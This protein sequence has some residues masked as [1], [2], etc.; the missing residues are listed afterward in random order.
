MGR[1]CSAAI[2]SKLPLFK[3]E[4]GWVG[5]IISCAHETTGI[6]GMNRALV[7]GKG[8]F[9]IVILSD[10][11]HFHASHDVLLGSLTRLLARSDSARTYVG[12]GKYTRPEVCSH[13][14]SEGAKLGLVW[15]EVEE[16]PVWRGGLPVSGGQLDREQLGVR[17]GMCRAWT[18]RWS[19]AMVKSQHSA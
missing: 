17:K 18:G 9:D 8:E 19:D 7:T 1:R 14:L 6:D 13:F 12:A 2:V 15:E 3:V 5:C 10:L 4:T 11:L 16:D